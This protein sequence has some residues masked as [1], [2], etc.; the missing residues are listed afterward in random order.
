M[1]E[2][3]GDSYRLFVVCSRH[4]VSQELHLY[5]KAVQKNEMHILKKEI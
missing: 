1:A 4:V 5:K 2:V 3:R